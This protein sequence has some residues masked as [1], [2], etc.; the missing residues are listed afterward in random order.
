VGPKIVYRLSGDRDN[1]FKGRPESTHAL[2]GYTNALITDI[3]G[4]IMKPKT[5]S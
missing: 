3:L 2:V 5:D 4:Y 1:C